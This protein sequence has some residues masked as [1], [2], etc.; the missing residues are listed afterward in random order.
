MPSFEATDPFP[1]VSLEE[2]ER[3]GAKDHAKSAD[4]WLGF[5]IDDVEEGVRAARFGDELKRFET[6]SHISPQVF[7]T[8]YLELRYWLDRLAPRPGSVVADLGAGYGRMAFVLER[9]FADVGF[10]GIECVPARVAE[11]TRVMRAQG[12]SRST[13]ITG[14]LTTPGFALPIADLYFVYDCGTREAV[15]FVI[16]RLTAQTHPG[17]RLLVRGLRACHAARDS[18]DWQNETDFDYRQSPGLHAE[19]FLR[20]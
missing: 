2:A 3:Q 19:I 17:T 11:A 12:L 20:T 14:D 1:L 5:R 7:L 15:E 4:A 18:V 6:W 16:K 8:P 9:H 13:L 10:V